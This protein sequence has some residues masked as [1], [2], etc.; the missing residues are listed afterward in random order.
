MCEERDQREEEDEGKAER[1]L[2]AER[3]AILQDMPQTDH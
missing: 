1:D 2:E 3:Q